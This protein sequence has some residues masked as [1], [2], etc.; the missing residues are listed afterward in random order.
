MVKLLQGTYA[1]CD[2]LILVYNLFVVIKELMTRNWEVKLEYIYREQNK[3]VDCLASMSMM[4]DHGVQ[5]LSSKEVGFF[6]SMVYSSLSL[7]VI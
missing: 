2:T 1:Y 6:S 7:K 3:V 4:H 5:I